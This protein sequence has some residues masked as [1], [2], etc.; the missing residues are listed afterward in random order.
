MTAKKDKLKVNTFLDELQQKG[1]FF[2]AQAFIFTSFRFSKKDLQRYQTNQGSQYVFGS[3]HLSSKELKNK[4]QVQILGIFIYE[5][6]S[7]NYGFV[8]AGDFNSHIVIPDKQKKEG[9]FSYV[10]FFYK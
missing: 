5:L 8:F 1:L 3:F 9:L 10:K 7:H 2:W 6:I 4:I